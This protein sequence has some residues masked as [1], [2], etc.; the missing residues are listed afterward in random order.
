MCKLMRLIL[1]VKSGKDYTIEAGD[2]KEKAEWLDVMSQ[3]RN[4]Y[5]LMDHAATAIMNGD[6]KD[7]RLELSWIL[8]RLH[9]LGQCSVIFVD[10]NI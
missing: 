7:V 6:F 8:L 5:G 9:F 10:L 4:T 3:A 2:E 1:Y